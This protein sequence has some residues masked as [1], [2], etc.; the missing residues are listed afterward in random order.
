MKRRAFI[1]ALGGAA[2]WPIVGRAQQ[3]KGRV[4]HIAYLGA[5]SPLALDPRQIE[6]FKR[7]LAE[8]GLDE[9]RNITVDYL[10]AD[11]SLEHPG[12]IS[13]F[14]AVSA[15]PTPNSHSEWTVGASAGY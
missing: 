9:S 1:A 4:A 15:A 7:G 12:G 8:N 6:Q 14:A 3:L 2:V 10:W 13:G 5:T 11:G